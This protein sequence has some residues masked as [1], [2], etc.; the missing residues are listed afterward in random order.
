MMQQTC[1]AKLRQRCVHNE[2][3]PQRLSI[4]DLGA[5]GAR[6]LQYAMPKGITAL[7]TATLLTCRVCVVPLQ[8]I[9]SERF[10]LAEQYP[11]PVYST[12][13]SG[14]CGSVILSAA[15]ECGGLMFQFADRTTE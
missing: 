14:W 7:Q 12:S 3:Y 11:R 5:R 6:C 4:L 9:D 13:V 1:Q 8:H 10:D 2:Q 15:L